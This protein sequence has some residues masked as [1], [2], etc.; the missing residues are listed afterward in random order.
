[1]AAS[2]KA[3]G[4]RWLKLDLHVHTPASKDYSGP[5]ITPKQFVDAVIAKGIDAIA[6][7]DHNTGEWIDGIKEAANGTPLAVFPGVEISVSGGKHGIHIIALFDRT[8]TT[9]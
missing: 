1:M 9:K 3:R 4:L 6:I 7:T 2:G 8:A 5:A